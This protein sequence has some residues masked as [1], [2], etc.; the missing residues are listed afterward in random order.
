[1]APV[2]SVEWEFS[3][4]SQW[5]KTGRHLDRENK[6]GYRGEKMNVSIIIYEDLFRQLDGFLIR[7]QTGQDDI[8]NQPQDPS[9]DQGHRLRHNISLTKR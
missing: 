8:F 3:I 1:M 2:A 6:E 7:Y 4:E 5:Q 9:R